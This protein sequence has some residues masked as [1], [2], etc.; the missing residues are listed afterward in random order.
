VAT[1]EGAVV[2]LIVVVEVDGIIE[3]Y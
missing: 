2:Y 3:P 1:S